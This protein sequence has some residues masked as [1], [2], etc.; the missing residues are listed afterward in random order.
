MA[1]NMTFVDYQTVVPADWLN[2]VNTVVNN[3]AIAFPTKTVTSITNLRAVLHTAASYVFV[4]GYYVSGD[5][6]G[7]PYYY[8]STDVSS[9]D[10]GGTVIVASDGGRWKLVYTAQLTVKQFGA[11]GD[12]STNDATAVQAALT[13]CMANQKALRFPAGKYRFTSALSVTFPSALSAFT[14]IGDG[15]DTTI[16]NWASGNGLTINYLGAYNSANIFDMSFTTSAS[17]SGNGLTLNQTAASIPNPALNA[18][19]NIREVV[20]RGDDGYVITDCWNIACNIVGVSNVDFYSCYFGGNA[21]LGGAGT[22]LFVQGTVALPPVVFNLVSCNFE[23]NGVGI[24]YGNFTQGFSVTGCNFV[25][26]SLGIASTTGLTDTD[27]LTVTACQF[28]QTNSNINLLTNIANTMLV[29]NEF[30]IQTNAIG[31]NMPAA[32]YYTITGNTLGGNGFT[33]TNGIVINNSTAGGVITGNAFLG[34]TTAVNLQAASSGVNVQSNSYT[35]CTTNVANA[36]A[37]NTVGGGSP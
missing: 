27:Q 26:G 23:W 16:L 19:T 35:S 6:G 3:P 10:N 7:G 21:A 24:G 13:F 36:G 22:G 18:L 9:I 5:G 20:F 31:I 2:N 37:G 8:D 34:C 33:N 32:G 28:N 25:G 17:V 4:T 29:G 12:G 11:K 14:M 15:P 1:I 30:I